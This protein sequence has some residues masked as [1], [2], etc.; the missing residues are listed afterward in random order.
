VL[1]TDICEKIMNQEEKSG[2]FTLISGLTRNASIGLDS[3]VH[4]IKLNPEIFE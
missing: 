1:E 3:V 4:R 2:R